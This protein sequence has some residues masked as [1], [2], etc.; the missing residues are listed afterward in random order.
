MSLYDDVVA[1]HCCIL[2]ITGTG[3]FQAVNAVAYAQ[4]KQG[5][6]AMYAVCP[7]AEIEPLHQQYFCVGSS[8]YSIRMYMCPWL[9]VLC[10]PLQRHTTIV[11]SGK[12]GKY[13]GSCVRESTLV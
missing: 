5:V 13:L 4:I 7:S 6:L 11:S 12:L 2:Y 8:S 3:S 10:L 1:V 9:V